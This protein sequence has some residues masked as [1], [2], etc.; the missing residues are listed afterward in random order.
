MSEVDPSDRQVLRHNLGIIADLE[1]TIF[2]AFVHGGM[3]PSMAEAYTFH[4]YK[5]RE[6]QTEREKLLR[7]VLHLYEVLGIELPP[8]EDEDEEKKT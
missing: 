5:Q 4:F 8:D 2:K 6:T 1:V 7:L 3:P